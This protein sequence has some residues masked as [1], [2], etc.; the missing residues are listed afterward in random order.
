MYLFAELGNLL[1]EGG[2]ISVDYKYQAFISYAHKDEAVAVRLHRALETYRIPKNLASESQQALSPIFRDAAELSAHHSL[3]EKIREAI[4]S[5][6]T[7]IVLCSP[8]AKASYWVNEEIRLFR[9]L[10][11][12]GSILSVLIEGTPETS[13]PSALLEGGREPLA[14]NL[15]YNKESFKLGTTQIAASML[16]VGLDVLIQRES[17]RRR[18][19]LQL[20]TASALV[21]S[22]V[23][24]GMTLTAI[25]AR[26][27]AQD[28]RAQAEG[29]VE[30]M[31]T[32]LKD[33]LEPVGRLDILD[34]IGD[35]AVDFYE[36]QNIKTL[37][38]ESLLRQA[39]ARLI[40]GQVAFD[41]IR[42]DDAIREI[43]A[44]AELT[45]EVLS[46]TPDNV[47]A[48]FAH[49]Q[50]EYWRG[51]IFYG[52]G[53]LDG[54]LEHWTNYDNLAQKLYKKAPDKAEWIMEAGYA[55]NTL[56]VTSMVQKQYSEAYSYY[57]EAIEYYNQVL[58]NNPNDYAA[59]VALANSYSGAASASLKSDRVA[60]ALKYKTRQIEIYDTILNKDSENF[61]LMHNRAIAKSVM[62]KQNLVSK[63][64]PAYER[65]VKEIV[66]E[67]N[68][69]TQ[70][71]PNN[72]VW[73]GDFERFKAAFLTK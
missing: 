50:S 32:D 26:N 59:L 29:L 42:K 36:T 13:F 33:K 71:D 44:A 24:G 51:K 47:E 40:L 27:D 54:V 73:K 7:L 65:L 61:S 56:G 45:S 6:R 30:Y 62:L 72:A 48:I 4:Q 38:D 18:R 3:P 68:I 28:S 14:A 17:K 11:G 25:D 23:M 39:R 55:K 52:Q 12:E 58:R 31:I 37:P 70:H 41:A 64:T 21:F 15:G 34:S 8:V 2:T 43:E 16:G 9:S 49:A 20:I 63:N 66:E 19:R 67:F 69:V 35:R 22:A 57:N 1:R 60:N 5:S 53:N 46:R 10:H